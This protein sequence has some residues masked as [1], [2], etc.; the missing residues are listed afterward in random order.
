MGTL[1]TVLNGA[2]SALGRIAMSFFEAYTQRRKAEDRIPITIAFFLPTT[3]VTISIVLFLILPGR[4]LL[5]AYTVVAFGNGF[6]ASVLILVMRTIYAKDAAKHYNVGMNGLWVSALL[7]N[8]L[9]YGEW[10]AVQAEK[11]N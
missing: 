8:R 1:L 11:Y 9:L 2:G 6:C 5:L 7:F 3:M 4:S 10:Y